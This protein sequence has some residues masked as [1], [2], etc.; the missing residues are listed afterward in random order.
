MRHFQLIVKHRDICR[1]LCIFFLV[2]PRT[3]K[4]CYV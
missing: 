2:V 3:V 1:V 4:I